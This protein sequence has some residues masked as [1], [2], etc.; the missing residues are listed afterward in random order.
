MWKHVNTLL[1]NAATGLSLAELRNRYTNA[2][3]QKEFDQ[4]M[5]YLEFGS[6]EF[7]RPFQYLKKFAEGKELRGIQA[8]VAHGTQEQC[9]TTL[10]K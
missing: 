10:L 4:L 7:Q 3:V 2:V 8:H 1:I 9:I 6:A 5:D